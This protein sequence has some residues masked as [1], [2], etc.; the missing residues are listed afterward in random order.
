MKMKKLGIFITD[1]Q[2]WTAEAL[3]K[4]AE[5]RNI[6]TFCP[7]M[8]KIG[9]SVTDR[10]EHRAVDIDLSELDAMIIRDMGTGQNDAHIFRFDVLRDLERNGI[11]IINSPA[12]IQN[13]ANKFHSSCLIANAG[14]STPKTFVTQ[15]V[16]VALKLIDDLGDVVIKPVF[17]YKGI[18][19][20]RIKGNKVIAPDGTKEKTPVFDL[21]NNIIKEKGILYIQE[22]IESSGKDIRAFIVDDNVIGAIYRK[23]PDGWWLNNLSQ[24]GTP[25]A[26]ELSGEQHEMCIE[27]ARAVGAFFAGVDIIENEK[28]CFVLEVNATPSGAGIYKSLNINVAEHILNAIEYRIQNAGQKK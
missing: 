12:A 5:K 26:C 22:F 21:V 10:V 17:G 25:Q 2:D 9:T 7:D 28:G 18:G 3:I 15:E 13:A 14:I 24:G 23:A 19:I 4:E 11:L 27:A 20:V 1:P 6:E 16:N 8:G